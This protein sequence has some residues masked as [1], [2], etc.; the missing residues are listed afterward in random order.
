MITRS[1]KNTVSNTI[2]NYFDRNMNDMMEVEEIKPMST[3]TESKYNMYASQQ[4]CSARDF[5]ME[6]YYEDV[7]Q[8]DPDNL[9]KYV[10][11][12]FDIGSALCGLEIVHKVGNNYELNKEFF[13]YY[14]WMSK[15]ELVKSNC[16]FLVKMGHPN[17]Q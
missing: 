13:D 16:K 10:Q 14:A 11:I 7:K 4:I 8:K 17:Y 2:H 15:E 6:E 9:T 1:K 5:S 3:M 12:L